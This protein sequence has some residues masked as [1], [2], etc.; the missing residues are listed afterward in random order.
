MPERKGALKIFGSVQVRTQA[1]CMAGE[2]FIHC[3][4]PL[5]QAE[6][7][8]SAVAEA[9][10]GLLSDVLVVDDDGAGLDPSPTTLR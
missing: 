4:M 10:K 7:L 2:N 6:G 8:T 9:A 5:G 1:A 3:A